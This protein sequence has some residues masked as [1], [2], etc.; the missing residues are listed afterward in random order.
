MGG[1]SKTS[2]ADIVRNIGAELDDSSPEDSVVDIITFVESPFW[3]NQKLYPVQ[4]VILK[5]HYGIPLEDTPE[6]F[7]EEALKSYSKE[8]LFLLAQNE[9]PEISEDSSIS[10][11]I[12]AILRQKVL[13]Y[14]DDA[15]WRKN[16]KSAKWLTEKEYLEYLYDEGRSNIRTVIPGYERRELILSI[17]RRS[18]KTHISSCIAAYEAYKL[19][20]KGNPQRYYGLPEGEVIQLISVATDRDQ[21]GILYRKVS[22]NFKNTSFFR[23]FAANETQSNSRFQTPID[24][25]DHGRWDGNNNA[26]A[27]INVTFRSCVAKG[28]RGAGNIVVILDEV[29]HFTNSGQSSAEEVYNAVSPSLSTFSPKNPDDKTVPI[30]DVEARMIMISSPLGRQGHFYDMFQI[31]MKKGDAS[32]G[33]LAIQAPTWEV[34]PTVPPSEFE[35]N[36]VKDPNTFMTE[37]GGHFSDRTL[38]WIEVPADLVACVDPEARP[39]TRG[40]YRVPYFIG[41]DFALKNDGTA[42]AI[43]HP[44]GENIV[45]DLVLERRAGLPPYQNLERL[46]YEDVADWVLELS[47][48]FLFEE[49]ICDQWSGIVFEQALQKR[50]LRQIKSVHHTPQLSS[51]MFKNFKDMMYE[52]R[53]VLYDDRP[54]DQRHLP[55]AE[56][57]FTQAKE[58]EDD[59]EEFEGEEEAE[60]SFRRKQRG[61]ISYL[62]ELLELQATVKSK[63]VVEVEAPKVPGKHDDRSDALVRMVWAA[64]QR[65]ATSKHIAGQ[66]RPIPGVSPYRLS[67]KQINRAVLRAKQG[68]THESRTVRTVR[69]RGGGRGRI[70]PVRSGRLK[71]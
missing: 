47:R 3:M 45:V 41:I 16:P 48:S 9:D 14:A 27:S 56:T 29:A 13:I 11:M 24:I 69:S 32:K 61:P 59:E 18:G 37:Y 39:R 38:G 57:G 55:L 31:A 58:E 8:N 5:A 67:Q 34:N 50:G 60:E 43:G 44:E 28:L 52:K 70:A 22:A 17:G 15:P 7:T 63:Y 40:Q 36:Y 71:G 49:G 2:L 23:T 19:L 66:T 35:K 1:V 12:R 30:G 51:Q 20:R 64:S 53:L 4:R 26:H 65:I 62:K 54:E 42:I 25:R 68:G 6:G 21:A 46:D 33:M 10:E